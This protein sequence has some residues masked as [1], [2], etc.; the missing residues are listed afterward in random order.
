M[1]Q[2]YPNMRRFSQFNRRDHPSNCS[3][4]RRHINSQSISYHNAKS[5]EIY[6]NGISKK[7][8]QFNSHE[9]Q[10][11]VNIDH[12]EISDLKGESV[13]SKRSFFSFFIKNRKESD[14]QIELKHHDK[15]NHQRLFVSRQENLI[16]TNN[17]EANNNDDLD[18]ECQSINDLKRKFIKKKD[19]T[20]TNQSNNARVSFAQETNPNLESDNLL[21]KHNNDEV[22][23]LDNY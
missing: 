22:N 1:L 6:E 12:T 16:E 14:P 23:E 11:I 15:S 17:R 7:S 10:D 19:S 3:I 9:I 20:A 18:E 2:R 5:N 13:S 8:Q 21:K 4:N